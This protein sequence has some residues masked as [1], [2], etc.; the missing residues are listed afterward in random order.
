MARTVIP[1]D[2]FVCDH[3]NKALSDSKFIATENA[4]VIGQLECKERCKEY[5]AFFESGEPEELAKEMLCKHI[6]QIR[7]RGTTQ[8]ERADI[9]SIVDVV[10]EE[11]YCLD[12]LSKWE[13]HI[14]EYHLIRTMVIQKGEDYSNTI[15]ASPIVF[16]T[17][18][19]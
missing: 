9:A 6:L 8:V 14:K 7:K 13:S 17:G 1:K 12:C 18:E 5:V 19:F 4:V 15:L 2:C 10:R 11:T 16:E 3:C